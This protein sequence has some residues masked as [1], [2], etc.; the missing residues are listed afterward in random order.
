MTLTKTDMLFE[1]TNEYKQAFQE[2]KNQVCEDLILCYFD[3]TK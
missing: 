3:P 2:L 1:W